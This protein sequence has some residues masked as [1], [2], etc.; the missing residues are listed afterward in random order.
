VK[1]AGKVA[2]VTGGANGI[3]RAL[4]RRFAVEGARAVVVADLD[5]AGAEQVAREV[6]GLAV[7]TDVSRE[8]DIVDLVER[9]VLLQCG[10]RHGRRRGDIRQRLAAHL[11]Y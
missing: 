2:V 5:S 6:G 1:L 4:C 3:G 9:A 11:G 10:H 7:R 8:A